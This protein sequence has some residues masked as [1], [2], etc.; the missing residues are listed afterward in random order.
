MSYMGKMFI[1]LALQNV[2]CTSWMIIWDY[3]FMKYLKY[4]IK[5]LCLCNPI[6]SRIMYR[7]S[8]HGNTIHTPSSLYF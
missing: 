6:F 1:V 2:V 3:I 4:K 7:S 5:H 8:V